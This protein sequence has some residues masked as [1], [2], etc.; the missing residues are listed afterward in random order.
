MT[1]MHV[2]YL[3]LSIIVKGFV[4]CWKRA[5]RFAFLV[6]KTEY[7]IREIRIIKEKSKKSCNI[8]KHTCVMDQITNDVNVLSLFFCYGIQT[9]LL[10]L[11]LYGL[12]LDC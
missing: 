3:T 5:K 11:C 6:E 7:I 12:Y 1:L 10:L 8:A 2:I 4:T 9:N